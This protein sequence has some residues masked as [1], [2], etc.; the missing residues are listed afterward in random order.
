MPEMITL[1][2]RIV[3]INDFRVK[4]DIDNTHEYDNISGAIMTLIHQEIDLNP[5]NAVAEPQTNASMG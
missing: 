4:G 3:V 1:A 2:D 5:V